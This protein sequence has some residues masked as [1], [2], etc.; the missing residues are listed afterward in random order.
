MLGSTAGSES[1]VCYLVR[2]IKKPLKAKIIENHRV[3]RPM[4][5]SFR[6]HHVEGWYPEAE[7]TPISFTNNA[8]VIRDPQKSEPFRSLM[9]GNQTM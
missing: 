3:T 6:S 4:P 2:R 8:I 9:M 7:S 1:H 5:A